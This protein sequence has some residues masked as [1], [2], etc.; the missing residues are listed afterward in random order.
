MRPAGRKMN[1]KSTKARKHEGAPDSIPT[2]N[3]S[4]GIPIRKRESLKA[5]KVE[6]MDPQEAG[7]IGGRIGGKSRSEAKLAACRRNG[8]KHMKRAPDTV[9]QSQTTPTVP[10]VLVPKKEAK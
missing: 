5:R 6:S 2:R 9:A 10:A 1:H 8:F 7:R 3:A 4:S